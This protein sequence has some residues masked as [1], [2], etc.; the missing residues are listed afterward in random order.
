MS[1]PAPRRHAVK[2]RHGFVFPAIAV[3]PA[4]TF[5]LALHCAVCPPPAPSASLM[6]SSAT[7]VDAQLARRTASEPA[8]RGRRAES[9]HRLRSSACAASGW[10]WA[11]SAPL[12]RS[13]AGCAGGQWVATALL[14]VLHPVV[15]RCLPAVERTATML[16]RV[17]LQ[18]QDRATCCIAHPFGG[19]AANPAASHLI[20][21]PLRRSHTAKANPLRGIAS[22]R[23]SQSALR[24]HWHKAAMQLASLDC[25]AAGQG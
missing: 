19:Y 1:H 9:A 17:S 15:R 18:G 2:L 13:L 5:A 6:A 3:P 25:H 4:P 7:L 22:Q 8:L 23:Q 14:A 24:V 11:A 12:A 21:A 10:L 16:G 20:P